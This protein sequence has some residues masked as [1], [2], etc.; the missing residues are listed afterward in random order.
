MHLRIS[1]V[2]AMPVNT[3]QWIWP[4]AS[5]LL[6]IRLSAIHVSHGNFFFLLSNAPHTKT[7]KL[8]FKKHGQMMQITPISKDFPTTEAPI[9]PKVSR[10]KGVSRLN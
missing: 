6:A 8:V 3:L 5:L 1:V 10:S 9:D 2:T 4:I 7:K